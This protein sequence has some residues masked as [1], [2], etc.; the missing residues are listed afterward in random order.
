[1][2]S[3][4]EILRLRAETDTATRIDPETLQLRRPCWAPPLVLSGELLEICIKLGL[5]VSEEKPIARLWAQ[6]ADPKRVGRVLRDTNP[7]R[8][9]AMAGI[10]C[11][12]FELHAGSERGKK[13]EMLLR[14]QRHSDERWSIGPLWH[15]PWHKR[16]EAAAIR[17]RIS[18]YQ[19][20]VNFYRSTPD[21]ENRLPDFIK[22][23]EELQARLPKAQQAEEQDYQARLER[24]Q[25]HCR[26]TELATARVAEFAGDY[27][28]QS[29]IA[30]RLWGHCSE[31]YRKLTDPK[32]LEIGIG[33]ECVQTIIWVGPRGEHVRMVEAIADGRIA[34]VNGELRWVA[35]P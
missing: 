35:A 6:F 10:S 27:D 20:H 17:E 32:S 25:L 9:N 22:E 34:A 24:Y 33:P 30:G 16:G 11:R 21:Y 8:K 15:E 28:A 18:T 3:S 29:H 31:C 19:A 1:M 12:G 4:F 7:D 26:A 23:L 2:T 14:A 13:S 5:P